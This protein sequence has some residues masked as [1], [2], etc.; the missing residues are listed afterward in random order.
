[1]TQT[2]RWAE[3]QDKFR[4]SEHQ[5]SLNASFRLLLYETPDSRFASASVD[6]TVEWNPGCPVQE[7]KQ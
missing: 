6:L 1:M 5:N 4:N 2:G 3:K 7:V